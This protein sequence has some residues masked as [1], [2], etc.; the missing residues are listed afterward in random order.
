MENIK[1][2]NN[3][4][5]EVEGK[6]VEEAVKKAVEILKVPKRQIKVKV[7]SEEQMGLFGMEGAKPAKIIAS[8]ITPPKPKKK[9]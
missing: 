4:E 6:T 8:I 9:P 3:V 2:K 7:V 5:I 1:N